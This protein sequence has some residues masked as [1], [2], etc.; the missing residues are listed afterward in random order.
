M[1]NLPIVL[2]FLAAVLG[3]GNAGNESSASK[4]SASAPAAETEWTK[5]K[6][7]DLIKD[8]KANEL[9]ADSKYKGKHL[10]VFGQLAEVS[11]TFGVLQGDLRLSTD[12][13]ELVTV[14]CLFDESERSRLA[15]IDKG[16]WVHFRGTG[17]GMTAGLYVGL[18]DCVL[19]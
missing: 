7:D 18:A 2:L 11:D 4:P 10:E 12:K 17:D 9:R 13:N 8:Y 14:K 19:K 16:S 6:A 3:C 5:V 15:D 1:K